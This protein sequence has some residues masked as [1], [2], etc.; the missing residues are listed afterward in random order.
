MTDTFQEYM[1]NRPFRNKVQDEY[2]ERIVDGMDMTD[3][4]MMAYE[5]L[6]EQMNELSDEDLLEDVK[7]FY[8]DLLENV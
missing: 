6:H 5:T 3:L 2:I 7:Q 4:V 8:P 1:E